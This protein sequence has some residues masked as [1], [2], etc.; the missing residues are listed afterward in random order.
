MLPILQ[1]GK[2]RLP[3]LSWHPNSSL[4]LW[5]PCT[6]WHVHACVRTPQALLSALWAGM[7]PFFGRGGLEWSLVDEPVSSC[8]VGMLRVK[9]GG[10]QPLGSPWDRSLPAPPFHSLSFKTNTGE[11]KPPIQPRH[12]WSLSWN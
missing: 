4:S 3:K 1:L 7:S 9:E 6:P 10:C 12:R 2:L 8:Q 11:P 5:S